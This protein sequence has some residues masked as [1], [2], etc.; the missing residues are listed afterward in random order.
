M[1][2]H[3]AARQLH[4]LACRLAAGQTLQPTSQHKLQQIKRLEWHVFLNIRGRDS[5][6]C[7]I[8]LPATAP[9]PPC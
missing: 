7:L 4:A 2:L 8:P 1:T 9:S 3:T 5:R 6:V